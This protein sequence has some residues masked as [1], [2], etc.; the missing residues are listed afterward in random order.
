MLSDEVHRLNDVD[1]AVLPREEEI[2]SYEARGWYRSRHVVPYALLE[3]VRTA[4][5]A[6]QMGHRDRVL[7]G[8]ANFSD[9]KPGDGDGVRN[10]EFCSLQNDTIRQ[11]AVLPAIGAIAARLARSPAMRIFDDQAVHKP[12]ARDSA[13]TA[14]VG[15]HTD[16]SYWSTCTSD[17]MLTAWIPLDDATEEMGTLWV[18]DGSHLWPESEHVRGFNDPDLSSIEARIGRKI[19]A[20]IVS[21]MT[22]EKGQVSFHHM[23]ALH[24]SGPNRAQKPRVALAVHMQDDANHHRPYATA[25]GVQVVLPHDQ[26]CRRNEAGLPDY[27]DP[28]VFP[29][30]WPTTDPA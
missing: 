21:P 7:P 26:L 23:R 30:I 19:P 5:E 6:H 9:W 29:Q 4:I 27:R 8:K 14:A 20:S 17:R 16:H 24:G 22:L 13:S 12:P 10:N 1:D 28:A 15:W 25:A 2:A 18:V 3:E 11:L